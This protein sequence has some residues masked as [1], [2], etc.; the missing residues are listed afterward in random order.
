MKSYLDCVPCF[1]RQGLDACHM[2]TTDEQAVRRLLPRILVT[3]AGSDLDLPPPV[4]VRAMHRV[5]RE[6]LRSPDPYK[7]LKKKST[8]KALSLVPDAE[9]LIDAS[10]N[11]FAAAVRFAIAGNILDFGAK[12]EWSESRVR[13]SFSKALDVPLTIDYTDELHSRL[14]TAKAVLFLGDNAGEAVFDRL[15]IERFPGSGTIYY[16]VKGSPVIN[17]VTRE[18]AEEA[19]IAAV[20]Q[21]ID[22]G[23]DIPGTHLP[24]TSTQFRE[25]F[26]SADVVISK[27]QG[28][29]ETL[30]DGERE[31]FC[32][33][34]IKCESLAKRNNLSLGDW[35]VTK[36][37]QGVH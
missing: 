19:G 28:N 2:I 36:T 29:F 6:E 18:E 20:A 30:L 5:I 11:P 35:I 34:Q 37:G 27:G 17:D 21:I 4:I 13:E 10:D 3:I 22:N 15:L 24:A 31:V 1:V 32:I 26:F 25:L 9:Q 23:T 12:T 16:A 33:L 7:A 14:K 8:E